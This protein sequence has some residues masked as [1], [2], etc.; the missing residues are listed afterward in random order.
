MIL[1]FPGFA[2]KATVALI[3]FIDCVKKIV[4]QDEKKNWTIN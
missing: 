1:C 4:A 3:R 2:L